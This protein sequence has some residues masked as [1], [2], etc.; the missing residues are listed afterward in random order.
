MSPKM[1]RPIM[2]EEPKNKQIAMR[3]AQSTV[4]KF[5]K[6]SDLSGKPKVTLFED[7][8]NALYEKLTKK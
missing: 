1:G 3:V 7:M 5:Q 2:G 6:C 8:V 4:D